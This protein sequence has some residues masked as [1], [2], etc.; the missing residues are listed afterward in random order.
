MSAARFD[1][2]RRGFGGGVEYLNRG[3]NLLQPTGLLHNHSLGAQTSCLA[4]LP[5]ELL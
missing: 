2:E 5:L 4:G 1:V 3:P